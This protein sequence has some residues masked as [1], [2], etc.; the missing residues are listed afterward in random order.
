MTALICHKKFLQNLFYLQILYY[1]VCGRRAVI[2]SLQTHFNNQMA[3][4]YSVGGS[5]INDKGRRVGGRGA[6]RPA[7]LAEE[8]AV[9]STTKGGEWEDAALTGL[10]SWPGR[11]QSGWRQREESGRTRRL[12]ACSFGRGEGSPVKHK[13]RSVGGRGAHRPALLAAEGAVRSLTKGGEW[14]CC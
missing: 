12:P 14:E 13:G 5:Q 6:H 3:Y 9:L 1:D 10:F 7:L 11:G 8:R 2:F 4:I